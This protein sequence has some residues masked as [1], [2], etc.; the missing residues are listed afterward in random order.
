MII[1][2]LSIAAGGGIIP[3]SIKAEM[4]NCAVINI[5]L[6]GTGIDC[7]KSLKQKVYNRI[8]PDNPKS[9]I[10]KYSHI[11]FL[12]IDIDRQSVKYSNN[13][14]SYDIDLYE[15]FLDLYVN[16]GAVPPGI[17]PADIRRKPSMRWLSDNIAICNAVAGAG[18]VRQVGRFCLMVNIEKVVNKIDTM[19]MQAITGLTKNT[20]IYIHI[21]TG[22]GGGT[23]SGIFLDICYILQHILKRNAILDRTWTCGYFFLPD[24]YQERVKPVTGQEYIEVNGFAAMKELDYCMNFCNN[25]GEW[26]QNYDTFEV[27]TNAQPVNLAHLITTKDEHG[28]IKPDGYNHAMNVVTDCVLEFM[29][30]LSFTLQS[31]ICQFYS[32][33]AMLQK[34]RG[35]CYSYCVLGAS[36]AYI[37]YKDINTYLV[38]KIFKEYD[39][40][41]KANHDVEDFVATKGFSYEEIIRSIEEDIPSIPTFSVDKNMLYEQVQGLTSDN[42][43]KVLTRM[44]DSYSEING[45]LTTNRESLCVALIESVKTELSSLAKTHGRGPVYAS[46][47]LRNP[48]RT[49]MDLIYIIDKYIVQNETNLRMARE[50]FKLIEGKMGTALN[51]FQDSNIFN[52]RRRAEEYVGSVWY[53]YMQYAKISKFVGVDEVLRAFKDQLSTLYDNTYSHL[54]KALNDISETFEGNLRVL[55]ENVDAVIENEIKI[56]G[57][58]DE[59]FK[60]FI[61]EY[62][63][64]LDCSDILMRFITHMIET[65]DE[66][67][68]YENSEKLSNIVSKFFVNELDLKNFGIETFLIKKYEENDLQKLVYLFYNDIMLTLKDKAKPLFWIDSIDG[69]IDPMNRGGYCSVPFASQVINS[70]ANQMKLI[71]P[72]ISLSFSTL[73]DRI[74]MFMYYRNIPM[75]QYKGSSLYKELYKNKRCPGTHLYEGI[76]EDKRDFRKLPDIIPFS[77]LDRNKDEN[78]QKFHECFLKALEH[79]IIYQ[80]Y[81]ETRIEYVLQIIDT[82]DLENRIK[83]I[84]KLITGGDTNAMRKFVEDSENKRIKFSDSIMLPNTG[85]GEYKESAVEDHI[86]ASDVLKSKMYAQTNMAKEYFVL[87]DQLVKSI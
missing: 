57:F 82:V 62:V 73:Q 36:N 33:V 10:T 1:N 68:R 50:N 2:E 74:S 42:I 37:P 43:P 26:N 66:W 25:G 78:L 5:G 6:G 7:L 30:N 41:P 24:V 45:K 72:R 87:L 48:S 85:Y 81:N 61:D 52:R 83:V 67:I 29:T 38:A 34:K 70:V 54:I 21:F 14:S 75:Y 12:A 56:V 19:I 18:G 15:E 53:Y 40:L 49:D 22:M 63:E 79:E 39:L 69:V 20:P 47:L 59:S 44:R 71:E 55:N 11:K 27:K 31:Y 17:K 65:S 51:K 32:I 60:N 80:K 64:N 16:F 58:G 86:F 13:E 28:A 76:G 9:L 23:G 4:H 46:L 3:D 35:V 77:L 8:K 84:N